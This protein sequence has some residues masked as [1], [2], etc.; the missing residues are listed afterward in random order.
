[1]MIAVGNKT[2]KTYLERKTKPELVRA[3]IEKYPERKE[4]PTKG[5]YANNLLPEPMR[6]YERN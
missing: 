5:H 2:G 1:M 3:L 6:F 4:K